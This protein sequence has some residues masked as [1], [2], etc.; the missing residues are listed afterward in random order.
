M[1]RPDILTAS[2]LYF[3]LVNP[4]PDM[5]VLYDIAHGLSHCAR[6]AGHT[7]SFYS[8]AQH[9]RLV[10]SIVPP[11]LKLQALLHDAAEAYVG[12]MTSPLKQLLPRFREIEARVWR[13]IA[14]HFEVPELLD[15]QIKHADL[16]ALATEQRDLM[17]PHDDEWTIL[18]GIEPL[19]EIL[20]PMDPWEARG[21]WLIDTTYALAESMAT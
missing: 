16:V 7:R 13:A 21:R 9:S 17:P 11:R 4:T 15:E 19:P 6:F 18:R 8:V 2:G 12:D 14:A 10:A 1:M 5:V 20:E 3:D